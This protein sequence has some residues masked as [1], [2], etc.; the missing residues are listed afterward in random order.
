MELDCGACG[1]CCFNPQSNVERGFTAYVEIDD[2]RSKLVRDPSLKRRYVS[3]DKEGR[4]HLRMAGDRCSA[5][6][7]SLGEYVRCVVYAHRPDPCRNLTA[8]DSD[9]LHARRERGLA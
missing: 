5:L 1:A 9:C 6:E 3:R 4:P 2:P 8:G 7:G